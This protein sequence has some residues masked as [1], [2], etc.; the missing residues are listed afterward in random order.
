MQDFYNRKSKTSVEN[1]KED[2][3]KGD[4]NDVF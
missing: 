1:L 4:A 2:L 3:I